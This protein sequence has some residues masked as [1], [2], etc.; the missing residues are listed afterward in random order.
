MTKR[1]QI[2]NEFIF[3][4][5]DESGFENNPFDHSTQKVKHQ[6]ADH[7]IVSLITKYLVAP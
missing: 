7:N 1:T 6:T 2:K 3:Y 4:N 5:L